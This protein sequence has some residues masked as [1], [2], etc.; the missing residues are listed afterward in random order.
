MQ[1]LEGLET[2]TLYFRPVGRGWRAIVN[3]GTDVFLCNQPF[4][5]LC[6]QAEREKLAGFPG[7]KLEVKLF[8]Y[9]RP[10]LWKEDRFYVGHILTVPLETTGAEADEEL[11]FDASRLNAILFKT[12]QGSLLIDPGSMGFDDPSAGIRR[13][14][15]DQKILVTVITHGHL[16]HWLHL[17]LVKEGLVYLPQTAFELASRHASWQRN[18]SLI[19][20]LSRAEIVGPGEPIMAGNIPAKIETFPLCHTI[21]E[22][23]GLVVEGRRRRVV[24]LSDF[25]L[26][27]MDAKGR[28]ETISRLQD[29]AEKP[30][31]CVAMNITNAHLPGFTP[32]EGLAVDAIVNIMAQSP[33]RVL[34]A[35]FA[36]N[37]DRIRALCEAA[38]ILNRP[39]QFFGAG[40][41]NT[42]EIF[43]L[44]ETNGGDLNRAVIFA[45][46][47]QAEKDSAL[48]RIA[49]GN[50]PPFEALKSDVA[51]FSARCIPG[52]EEELRQFHSRFRQ[53]V[54]RLIINDGDLAQIGGLENLGIEEAATHFSGHEYGGGQ[55][56][57]LQILRPK[58]ALVWPQTSPRIEAFRKIAEPLGVEIIPEDNRIIEI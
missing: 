35:C 20:A 47:C 3:N 10:S 48:W 52:N 4:C 40:M 44:P 53:L 22:T 18:R 14:I 30:V 23:M 55:Q 43:S 7:G 19:E 1:H 49:Y 28:A 39:V 5:E 37:F 34:I 16:D 12:D 6:N 9:R 17:G 31:D 57:V 25:R 21:P 42:K 26:S 58:S 50:N 33:G 51:V 45:T 27:G 56:L 54:G 8:P 24:V 15:E 11:E 46:G 38:Q 2:A 41:R 36:S 32:M 29:V 13:L